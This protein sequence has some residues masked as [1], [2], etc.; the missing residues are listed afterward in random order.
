MA[1]GL[2]VFTAAGDV[3]FDSSL[4]HWRYVETLYLPTG[5]SSSKSYAGVEDVYEVFG[6]GFADNLR[7]AVHKITCSGTT[8]SWAFSAPTGHSVGTYLTVFSR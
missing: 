4:R 2:Q 5:Q 8:V 6:I 1:H 3:L 7:F